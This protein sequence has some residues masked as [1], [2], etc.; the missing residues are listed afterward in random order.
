MNL[1]QYRDLKKQLLKF[2][3]R[4]GFRII[5]IINNKMKQTCPEWTEECVTVRETQRI[6]TCLALLLIPGAMSG[7][8]LWVYRQGEWWQGPC[9]QRGSLQ[10][11]GALTRTQPCWTLVME[12]P[13]S[14]LA[15]HRR[16]KHSAPEIRQPGR[17]LFTSFP[18]CS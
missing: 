9:A 11:R 1:L 6:W 3:L 10:A 15:S 16:G 18:A 7:L 5:L 4:L 2:L 17:D 14:A 12:S 13:A 8:S